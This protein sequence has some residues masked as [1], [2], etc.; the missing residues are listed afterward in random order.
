MVEEING[1]TPQMHVFICV[2]DRCSVPGNTKSSCS[3]SITPEMV[4]E[5]KAWLRMKG[6]GG[7]VYCTQVKCLGFCNPDGGVM[8]VYPAGT[9]FKGLRT[10]SD[11]Q[12]VVEREWEK[13]E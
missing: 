2:N 4:K 12:K 8:C 11:I 9:F 3:P 10:V 1:A 5:V 6:L 13:M 7:R